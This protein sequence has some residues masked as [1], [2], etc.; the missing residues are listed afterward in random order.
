MKNVSIKFVFLFVV[1]YSI[2]LCQC[3]PHGPCSEKDH[4]EKNQHNPQQPQQQQQQPLTQMSTQQQ[5]QGEGTST[6]GP[7]PLTTTDRPVQAHAELPNKRPDLI[8]QSVEFNEMSDR[9]RKI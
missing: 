7:A 5:M 8:I 1:F 3:C 6:A 4:V 2:T 9:D